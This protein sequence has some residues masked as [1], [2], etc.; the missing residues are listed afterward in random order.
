MQR[1][2][3]ISTI[4]TGSRRSTIATRHIK[5]TSTRGIIR[6]SKRDLRRGLRHCFQG[7]PVTSALPFTST[8]CTARTPFHWAK[9][10]KITAPCRI[11]NYLKGSCAG[12]GGD[13]R[14][15]VAMYATQLKTRLSR[16]PF[17][18]KLNLTKSHNKD[19]IRLDNNSQLKLYPKG[20]S[21]DSPEF[22]LIFFS[23]ISCE[24]HPR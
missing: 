19:D 8:S 5:S 20:L 13:T 2:Y 10:G 11:E 21:K 17:D 7:E 14:G 6:R 9:M 4:N 1:V 24:T 22:W 16:A 3:Q 15:S 12:A 23:P 18:S